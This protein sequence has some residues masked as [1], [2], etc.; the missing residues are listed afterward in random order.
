[1]GPSWP[2]APAAVPARARP[3][4]AAPVR[5]LLSAPLG[6]RLRSR[7]KGRGVVGAQIK[8]LPVPQRE[9]VILVELKHAVSEA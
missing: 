1:M 3:S 9:E 7:W 6:T 8:V 4:P 2:A 5:E